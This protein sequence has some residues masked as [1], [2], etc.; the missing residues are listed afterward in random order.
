VSDADPRDAF[1]DAFETDDDPLARYEQTFARVDADPFAAFRDRVLTARD[2]SGRTLDGHDR[3]WRQWR[4]HMA[5]QGR[6]PACPHADHVRAFARHELDVKGNA[7]R[8]VAEKLRKLN[9]CY[10]YWQADP[11]FPH[12]QDYNPVALARQTV[13]LSYDDRKEP[14]HIPLDELRDIVDSVETIRD[15]AIVVCQLKL[16]LRA[17]ELCNL[18]IP[19]LAIDDSELQRH[20]PTLG[21]HDRLD[22]RPNA[23]HIPHDREGNKSRRPRVLPLDDELRQVLGQYLRVRPQSGVPWVVLSRTTH[24]Q[25]RRKAV[26]Q[27]WRAAFHPEY[28]ESEEHRAVTS[29]YGRHRFT[30][31]WTVKQDL[32]RELVKYLRGDTPGSA[33][34][35]ERGAVDKY[36]HSYY[37]D[38][39]QR[40][41][42]AIYKIVDG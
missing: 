10:Q 5:Q 39:K 35:E 26:N 42:R 40:Y 4:E 29:H 17:G 33:E 23:I 1:A 9:E 31:Y 34:I 27:L 22:G 16:G 24:G 38:I 2:V 41:Q 20:Y 11:A 18:Q 15:H 12:P 14:P 8:T 7:P 3:V 6:H 30:T 28:A 37:A 21:T 25:L 32:N 36:I 13:D 19:D